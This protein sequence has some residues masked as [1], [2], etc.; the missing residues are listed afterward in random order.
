MDCNG[1]NTATSGSESA[2]QPPHHNTVIRARS[3]QSH[4]QKQPSHRTNTSA[5]GAIHISRS[6]TRGNY[7][8]TPYGGPAPPGPAHCHT[9]IRDDRRTGFTCSPVSGAT[10]NV[11]AQTSPS[12]FTPTDSPR[13]SVCRHARQISA[14]SKGA[15]HTSIPRKTKGDA[16][17][18]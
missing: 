11:D 4:E 8:G 9:T 1:A 14:K 2:S 13:K 6:L 15:Y 3:R 12:R 10:P 18:A 16:A 17:R 5:A 7:P